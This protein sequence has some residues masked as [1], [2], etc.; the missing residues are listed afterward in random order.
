MWLF[1]AMCE[2]LLITMICMYVLGQPSINQHGY[3]SNLGL[4]SVT[5]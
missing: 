3:N 1:E 2:A 4:V 5:V